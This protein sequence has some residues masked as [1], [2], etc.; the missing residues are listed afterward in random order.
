MPDIQ[1]TIW[2]PLREQGVVVLGLNPGGLTGNDQAY[3]Q[4]YVDALGLTF[5]V[6]MDNR[7]TYDA[8]TS[9]D[10]IAPFPLD[11]VVDR[12]GTVLLAKRDFDIDLILATI[13]EALARP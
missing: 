9:S 12:D 4:D 2:E 13:E 3:V 1:K 10:A 8:Y 6:L 7:F 5:P 11:V